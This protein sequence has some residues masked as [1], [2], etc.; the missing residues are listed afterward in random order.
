MSVRRRPVVVSP[1]QR[2][3]EVAGKPLVARLLLPV[4]SARLRY[5]LL[6]EHLADAG[7]AGGHREVA[8]VPLQA[9]VPH[10]HSE[11]LLQAAAVLL[12]LA[13]AALR[14]AAAVLP[15]LALAEPLLAAVRLAAQAVVVAQ[16]WEALAA[17]V[18][19]QRL[20]LEVLAERAAERAAEEQLSEHPAAL[21]AGPDLEPL[22]CPV[23]LAR[24]AAADGQRPDG[25]SSKLRFFR[26]RLFVP[27]FRSPGRQRHRRPAA[28]KR[29]ALRAS[30][31]QRRRSNTAKKPNWRW[32]GAGESYRPR[33]V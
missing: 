5:H 4:V 22:E 14:L 10:W 20:A 3:P 16:P 1:E 21:V 17:A 7:P 29:A 11:L 28:Q 25:L 2:R 30:S 33:R 27:A 6:V 15:R 19:A 12:Q 8:Q 26:A 13:L 32:L 24:H 31:R 23:P 18:V 9:L